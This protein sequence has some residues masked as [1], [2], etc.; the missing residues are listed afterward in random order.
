MKQGNKQLCTINPHFAPQMDVIKTERTSPASQLWSR[1]FCPLESPM[2]VQPGFTIIHL[3]SLPPSSARPDRSGQGRVG[4]DRAPSS[5]EGI[6]GWAGGFVIIISLSLPPNE[7]LHLSYSVSLVLLSCVT[8]DSLYKE[9]QKKILELK[10]LTSSVQQK[11]QNISNM[12]VL[13]SN[14]TLVSQGSQS[15]SP[16][17][18]PNMPYHHL[19]YVQPL[20]SDVSFLSIIFITSLSNYYWFSFI[21]IF[22][23]CISIIIKSR[24]IFFLYWLKFKI[25]K[26]G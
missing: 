24:I 22:I 15:A 8:C 5:Y 6:C 9:N 23:N 20:P 19:Q 2:W 10:K 21:S 7:S 17:G 3:P 4:W 1:D 11:T 26:H 13:D 18:M 12:V 14:G 16:R 25:I